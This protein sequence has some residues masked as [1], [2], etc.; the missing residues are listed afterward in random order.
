MWE[1]QIKT[2]PM[3][4]IHW[5]T[6]AF[7]LIVENWEEIYGLSSTYKVL[8]ELC[9]LSD[10]NAFENTSLYELRKVLLMI[11]KYWEKKG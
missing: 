7:N 2:I 1:S 5:Y 8:M 6:A 9:K 3:D 10:E 4:N 11:E